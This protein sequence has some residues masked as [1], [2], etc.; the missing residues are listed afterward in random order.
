MDLSGTLVDVSGTSL[1]ISG[2]LFDMSAAILAAPEP[3]DILT[4]AEIL[5]EQS[6]LLAKELADGDAIRSLGTTSVLGL[7]PVFVE[8]VTK[9]CPDNYPLMKVEIKPPPVC[10]DG[11]VRSLP[12]YIEFCSGNSLAHHIG[13]LQAKL[14]DIR[15]AFA[16]LG[17]SVAAILSRV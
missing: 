10:S 9:G 14:P 13:L 8:W 3:P 1:D 7:K 11:V 5:G 4:M 6:L 16:N 15:V 12:D 17:G 2:S